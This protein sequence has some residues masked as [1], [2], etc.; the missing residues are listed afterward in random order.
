MKTNASIPERIPWGSQTPD[1][2]VLLS[3]PWEVFVFGVSMLSIIN[4]FLVLLMR[5]PDVEQ[6]V[7]LMD[8]VLLVIFV[9]DFVRRLRVADDERAYL[10][11]GKGWLD[12]IS[13]A[14]LLRIARV[15]RMLRTFRVVRR[16]GG[17]EVAV[18]AFFVNR[19]SGSLYVVILT[20]L[21][22]LEF[23][24]IMVLWAERGVEGANILTAGDALWYSL[25]TMSTVG[26]GDRFPVSDLGR[27]FGALT[28]IV[29]VGV[30]GTLTGFLANAF[31]SPSGG[32]G[33]AA[34]RPEP[35]DP[36][37]ADPPR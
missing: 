12:L 26:Y 9:V 19:A 7:V 29:G 16:M 11:R 20:A 23:G 2:Q 28:I 22:V 34:P 27:I 15:L 37:S 36:E 1:G 13:I 33:E 31:L 30:F 10:T 4:M 6:V 17:L 8:S 14:P 21:L 25:V 18:R 35:V 5:N 3:M 32:E 24:S